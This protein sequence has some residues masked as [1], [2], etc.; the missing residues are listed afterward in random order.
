MTRYVDDYRVSGASWSDVVQVA[1]LIS[2]VLQQRGL[3]LNRRKWKI[4]GRHQPQEVHGLNVNHGAC[5]PKPARKQLRNQVRRVARYSCTKGERRS[6]EGRLAYAS[7]L[8]PRWASRLRQELAQ[9]PTK[10]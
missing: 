2:G 7:Q 8:H 9:A 5:V 10:G 6:L 4:S 1:D 3:P